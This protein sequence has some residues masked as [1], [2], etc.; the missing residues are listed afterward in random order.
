VSLKERKKLLV[1]QKGEDGALRNNPGDEKEMKEKGARQ[2]DKVVD[3]M[4]KLRG[5]VK[6]LDGRTAG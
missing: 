3:G 1:R 2:M 6:G 5:K 4:T